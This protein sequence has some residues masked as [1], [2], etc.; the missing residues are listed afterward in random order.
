[1]QSYIL[2]I[3][4]CINYEWVRWIL[5][6]VAVVT[7]GAVL[8]LTVWQMLAEEP[9][10]FALMITVVL[11]ALHIGFILLF[12]VHYLLHCK[13]KQEYGTCIKSPLV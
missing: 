6:L 8:T 11:A 10:Q 1:M 3:L 2:Q 4:L 7:S 9:R 5:V 13:M 12:K